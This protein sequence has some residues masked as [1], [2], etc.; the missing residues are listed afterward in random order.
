MLNHTIG[1][2]FDHKGFSKS[3]YFI[4][5][6]QGIFDALT[7]EKFEVHTSD[8]PDSG[9]SAAVPAVYMRGDVDGVLTLAQ[10]HNWKTAMAEL[11]KEPGFADK[12]IVGLVERL[13]G[14]SAVHADDIEAG[15][16]A[17]SHLLAL[18]H[19]KVLVF[20]PLDIDHRSAHSLRVEGF[21]KA[22]QE[23]GLDPKHTIVAG[24]WSSRELTA[25]VERLRSTLE[26]D[27]SITAII[28]RH[29][30]DAVAAYKALSGF[31]VRVPEDVSLVGFDDSDAITG[32]FGENI[33]T[34]VRLPLQDIG[35]Q[36]AKLLVRRIL[37]QE[38]EDQD[39]VLPVEMVVRRSTA[40]PK[41]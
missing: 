36:G 9:G 8:T 24:T 34:T 25:S 13:D 4:Q 26:A 37:G 41:S 11:R 27:P 5:V 35:Y 6:L 3:N 29:D 15:R 2:F 21:F 17:M 16:L 23:F 20:Y 30:R 19:R 32:G 28:H 12:P 7:D 33:L 1:L 22:C 38:T 18:G 40:A 14:C 10:E 39:I 31:G